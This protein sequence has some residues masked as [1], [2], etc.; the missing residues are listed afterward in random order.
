[1]RHTSLWCRIC[2][3]WVTKRSLLSAH[4][5]IIEDLGSIFRHLPRSTI[6]IYT[7]L[8]F[9]FTQ[10]SLLGNTQSVVTGPGSTVLGSLRYFR[11]YRF[12]TEGKGWGFSRRRVGRTWAILRHQLVG[13]F[14]QTRYRHCGQM[15]LAAF[16]CLMRIHNKHLILLSSNCKV[17]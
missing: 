2:W 10:P 4:Q 8:V 7:A 14:V 16:E 1:M 11:Q 9:H 17:S 13:E 5:R 15:D 12:S 6:C 3:L